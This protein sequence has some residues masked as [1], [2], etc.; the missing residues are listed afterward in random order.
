[1]T[2][3][4]FK[5]PLSKYPTGAIIIWTRP[6]D[7]LPP[8]WALCDGA[9]GTPNLLKTFPKGV[10]DTATDPGSTGG[11]NTQSLSPEH[12]PGHAHNLSNF[13]SVGDHVHIKTDCEGR[14]D[15]G[16]YS[17]LKGAS[18]YIGIDPA[19]GHAHSVE[20]TGT[21]SSSSI[22]NQPPY[23]GHAYIMKLE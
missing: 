8:G 11:T 12:L 9:N 21:G 4:D 13:Q 7:E 6:L 14:Y 18:D 22:D 19:G 10:P 5:G 2:V 15:Y 23:E 17:E 20:T 1:M 16:S 3:E